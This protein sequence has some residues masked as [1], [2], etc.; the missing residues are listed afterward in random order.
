M[1]V[2]TPRA[3]GRRGAVAAGH[4]ETAA[5]AAEILED[6]GTAFDAMVAALA[7]SFVVEPA[8]SSPGGGGFLLAHPAGDDPVVLDFFAQTPGRAAPD[9]HVALDFLPVNADFGAATQ[10]FHVGRAAAAVP[11]MV[12]GL[13]AI[14]REFCRLPLPRLL[15]PAIRLA[16]AGPPVAPLQAHIVGVIA[17]ILLHTDDAR[18]VFAAPGDPS[19]S[20]AA[21]T[22]L[23]M[24]ALADTLEALGREGERLFRDGP[25]GQATADLCADG[26]LLTLEDIQ[27]YRVLRH[28]PLERRFRGTRIL[29]NPPPS[30]GGALMSF[31]LALADGGAPPDPV[32]MA[33]IMHLTAEA[34]DAVG[35]ALGVDDARVAR[36]LE[37]D[38]L[39]RWRAALDG[40]ARKAGG[41][42]HVSILDGLGNAAACTV[43]NGEGCGHMVPGM[44]FMLNNML[45]EEDLNPAGFFQWQPDTRVSSMMAP[46]LAE[47]PDGTVMALGS[48]GSN[49]IRT[50]LLQVLTGLIA[51]GRTPDA[52]VAA[53]RLHV[54]RG[55]LEIEAGW[56]DETVAALTAAFPNHRLWPDRSMFF[57]GVHITVRHAGGTFEAVGDPRRGGANRLV[58]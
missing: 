4:D 33:A 18:A 6:G 17:P 1:T 9:D 14:Q 49:R 27:A 3:T 20:I 24:L 57:G 52:A 56:D 55:H 53:P 35:L 39:T 45:G 26:G 50:A 16:R 21:G 36:L 37:D 22:P 51:D 7:A 10:E 54:E 15:E 2:G 19:R 11:G 13:C 42:T 44:G 28:R 30:S 5:A 38:A 40:R 31:G 25:A 29:T 43:S 41:T 34:R 48:G 23:P 12:P 58:R 32:R 47:R 46:T 8:L